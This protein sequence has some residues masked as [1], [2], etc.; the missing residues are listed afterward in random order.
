[1]VLRSSR[2]SRWLG[3]RPSGVWGAKLAVMIAGAVLMSAMVQP[4]G[5]AGAPGRLG[6]A[7]WQAATHE[8][9]GDADAYLLEDRTDLYVGFAVSKASSDPGD[10]VRLFLWSDEAAYTFTVD[11]RGD[12][13][14]KGSAVEAS[15]QW[16]AQTYPISGAYEVVMRLPRAFFDADGQTRW[17]VQLARVLPKS[18]AY[19]TWPQSGRPGDVA[20]AQRLDVSGG[21]FT[22]ASKIAAPK[23]AAAIG[24]HA[25]GGALAQQVARIWPAQKQDSLLTPPA[26]PQDAQGVAIAQQAQNVAFAGVDA[27]SADGE[28]NAQ[29]LA[30]TSS[31]QHASA[32]VERI[33]QSDGSSKDVT[34]ALSFS[35]DNGSNVRVAAGVAADSGSGISDASRATYDYYDFSVYGGQGS[36]EMRWNAAGP[37]YNPTDENAPAPG[38]SGYTLSL[39]R[40]FGNVS[41]YAQS[42]RYHDGFG[43]LADADQRT[44]IS[45]ALSPA[46]TFDLDAAVNAAV[47]AA[48]QYSTH[49]Y[50]QNGASLSYAGNGTQARFSYHRDRYQNGSAQEASI[51]GGFSLPLLGMLEL[52]HSRTSLLGTFSGV[53]RQQSSSAS[54]MHRLRSGYVSLGY[55]NTSGL[56]NIT[57]SFEERLPIG[58]IRA[59]YY[60][61]TT[62]FSAPNFSLNLVCL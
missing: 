29:S 49:P 11:R 7:R 34:Q 38:T 17:L 12:R 55:Q 51:S 3:G 41:L 35:Y 27:K 23:V 28:K 57:F 45:A 32:G 22:A 26:L 5:V 50:A 25:S 47:N 40:D 44:A 58:V 46:L 6:S 53:P 16:S 30:W 13:S 39:S 48:T 4:A 56:A 52:S 21:A 59:T 42:N 10:A 14:A 60:R 2:V 31:D 54:L 9:F 19:S 20:D 37:Q 8:H 18:G 24:P 62:M 36:L 1:M 15:P 61:P 43:N 33:A